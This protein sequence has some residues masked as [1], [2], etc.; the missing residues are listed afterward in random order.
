MPIVH[1]PD[2]QVSQ[3]AQHA[4]IGVGA[5]CHSCSILW[6][7]RTLLKE[8]WLW[9]RLERIHLQEYLQEQELQ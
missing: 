3:R 8:A 6:L 5:T 4:P 1:D 2:N 7:K 9:S